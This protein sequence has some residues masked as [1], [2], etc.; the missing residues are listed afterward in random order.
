MPQPNDQGTLRVRITSV[1]GNAE[2][3]F[4][5]RETIG[6][7]HDWSYKKLVRDK[8]QVPFETTWMEHGG[9]RVDDSQGLGSLV[10]SGQR[11]PGSEV[12]LTLNLAWTTQG[13]RYNV[14]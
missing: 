7:V 13:G 4:Q 5:R 3:P 10:G 14:T 9:Q 12:D 11:Q 6:D 1:D 2:H 8:A